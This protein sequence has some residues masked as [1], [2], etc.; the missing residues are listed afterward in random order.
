MFRVAEWRKMCPWQNVI[1]C[2][3]A[4]RAF[5]VMFATFVCVCICVT[6]AEGTLTAHS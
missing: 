4:F 2:V 3:V 1:W 6:H 5:W